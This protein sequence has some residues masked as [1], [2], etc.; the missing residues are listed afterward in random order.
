M[1]VYFPGQ[2]TDNIT[3]LFYHSKPEESYR[4]FVFPSEH[5]SPLCEKGDSLLLRGHGENSQR[6]LRTSSDHSPVT[7]IGPISEKDFNPGNIRPRIFSFTTNNT[8]I[9]RTNPFLFELLKLEGS[10]Y[11][12]LLGGMT[13]NMLIRA[14]SEFEQELAMYNNVSFLILSLTGL[15]SST[16]L[17]VVTTER[18]SKRELVIV[19]VE[20]LIVV[21]F[22]VVVTHSL[23]VFT[24]ADDY[25]VDY[26]V[27]QK[28][29]QYFE[30]GNITVIGSFKRREVTV[31]KRNGLPL[32]LITTEILAF[33]S[34]VVVIGNIVRLISK[35]KEED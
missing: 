28:T 14:E 18:L 35:T 31:G 22:L 33:A 25:V 5:G 7:K 32:V 27:S 9:N 10:K 11:G 20:G 34:T 26:Y 1:S 12:L 30:E 24:R 23:I 21:L 13:R 3:W 15:V 2:Q 16:V 17:V 19:I 6:I 29:V 4:V 8:M